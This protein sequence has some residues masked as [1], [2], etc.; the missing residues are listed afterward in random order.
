[1]SPTLLDYVGLG[2]QVPDGLPGRSFA[3]LLRGA[4]AP[5]RDHIV[6]VDEYGP[7]RM[8]RAAEWKY[9][10]RYPYG[11]H[12]LYDL[13]T[14][15][16][17]R[18]NRID[19]AGA[20]AV[21]ALLRQ[22]LEVWFCQFGSLERDGARQPVTGKGQLERVGPGGAGRPAFADDW[23]YIDEHGNPRPL[24]AARQNSDDGT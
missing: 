17:E 15:P 8:I 19:D 10:H 21:L 11:P 18:N 24:N 1:M 16:D 22:Q 20:S 14:D 2:S 23:H 5:A 6:V 7:V 4:E 9:V 13:A 12:E 3:P